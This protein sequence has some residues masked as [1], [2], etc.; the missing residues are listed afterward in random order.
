M[1]QASFTCRYCGKRARTSNN[2]NCPQSPN[3]KHEPLPENADQKMARESSEYTAM[4]DHLV[5]VHGLKA[6]AVRQV[7]YTLRGVNRLHEMQRT[8]CEEKEL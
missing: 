1:S 2:R 6:N 5:T 8:P 4:V 3:G 7:A